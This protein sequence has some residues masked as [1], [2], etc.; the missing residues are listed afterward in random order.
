MKRKREK[1]C[2]T[3]GGGCLLEEAIGVGSREDIVF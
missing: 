1:V 3:G 2:K